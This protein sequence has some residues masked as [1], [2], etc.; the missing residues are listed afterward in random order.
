MSQKI[1]ELLQKYN[2]RPRKGLGQNFLVDPHH[3]GRIIE[4]AELTPE[5]VVLEI[6]PGPGTLTRLLV[7]SARQVIA[8]EL[9]AAMVNLLRQELGHH[10][11]LAL[12]QADILQVDLP[13]LIGGT[14]RYKVVANLP[15]YITSAVLRHILETVPRPACVVVTVQKEV[16]QRIVA[17]P[18]QMS[19]LAVSVQFYGRPTLVHRIPAGAF[20][21]PPKVDSAVLRIDPYPTPRVEVADVEQFFRVVRAGFGKKRKQ[22]RNA[23]SA[24]L[25]RPPAQ[26][27]QILQA[28]GIDPRRRAETL[29]LEEWAR[30]AAAIV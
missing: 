17:S 20:Y 27:E 11:N 21:P 24:G 19:L 8:V 10:S 18:G 6:G 7:E 29:S 3:L 16:A 25:G 13:A 22:L 14:R 28:A 4:A 15:Y 1:T 2:L 9:D 30:L 26:V 23:L 12:V 5:D